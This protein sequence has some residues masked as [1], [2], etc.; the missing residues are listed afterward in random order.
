MRHQPT[1][2]NGCYATCS[3]LMT[4]NALYVKAVAPGAGRAT[5]CHSHGTELCFQMFSQPC[6]CIPVLDLPKQVTKSM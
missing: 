2:S 1:I 4:C 6:A 5:D 3:R